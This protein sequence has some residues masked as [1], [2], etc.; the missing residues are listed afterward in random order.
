MEG[1]RPG[2]TT[3]N[4]IDTLVAQVVASYRD[5]PTLVKVDGDDYVNPDVVRTVVDKLRS[6]V[7]AGFFSDKPL[8]WDSVAYY[9]GETLEQV[10]HILSKQVTRA[11]LRQG[12]SSESSGSTSYTAGGAAKLSPQ[13]AEALAADVVYEF[14]TKLP[15]VRAVLATDVDATF[16]GDPAA[17]STDEV[18]LS[19]PGIVA[20]V[21][22]RLAHELYL[23][24][25]PLIPR[26][27]S[28]YAHSLTG[29]DIHPGARIGH[30]FMID[31]GTGIVI[32]ETTVI[33][34]RVKIYQ[35]VTIGALS[36]T[37]GRSLRNVKRHPTIES[38]VTIYS[39]A[40]ILGADTVVGYGSVVGSNAFITKSVPARTRVSIKDPELQW[41]S[42]EPPVDFVQSDFWH[43]SI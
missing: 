41:K 2:M 12:D 36:T 32:G 38:A 18:V 7:L 28:E 26:L 13:E 20:I 11:L 43:Y 1:G 39:G 42:D 25:V 37:G 5:E 10:T 15:E 33:G 14:L 4:R 35:G 34:D 19:Y 21:V 23:L 40:S 17:H 22:Y 24:D 27:M 29:I 9:V 16:D 3:D 6:L 8:H 30:H 31:H